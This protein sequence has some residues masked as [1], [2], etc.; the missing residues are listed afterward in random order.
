MPDFAHER[1]IGG[2]VAGVDEV[3]RGPLAGPVLAA[4]A[5]LPLDLD[6]RIIDL[7]DD[8]KRLSPQRRALALA[9][10]IEH[11]TLIALGAASVREIARLNIL[12]ASLLAMRRAVTRLPERP[13][14]VLVDGTVAP[15]L[16]MACTTLIGGDGTS[17]S[18]ATASIAAKLARD[19]LMARLDRRY[20]GYS[21]SRNAGY[22]TLAHRDAI[23][24]LGIT[25]HH[26]RGFGPLLRDGGGSA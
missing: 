12:Q 3:G 16:S 15:G 19:R 4:A 23:I 22:G 21:W 8:S 10:L 13:D 24:S 6:P 2:V 20:P 9:A 26:R 5:I 11:G 17:L 7:I 1:R 18:I 25:V 14:H